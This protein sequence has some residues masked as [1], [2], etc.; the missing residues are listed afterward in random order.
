MYVPA[1]VVRFREMVRDRQRQAEESEAD[2]VE[3]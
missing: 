2:Q 3:P 1:I